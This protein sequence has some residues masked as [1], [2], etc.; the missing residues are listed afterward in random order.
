MISNDGQ[1]RNF[2]RMSQDSFYYILHLVEPVIARENTKYRN[3]LRANEKLA[4]TLRFLA[5]GLLFKMCYSQ[6]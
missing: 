4:I 6:F 2:F 3:A 1:Y 5:T